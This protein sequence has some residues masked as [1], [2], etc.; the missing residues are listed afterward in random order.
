MGLSKIR[1]HFI[2]FN[3]FGVHFVTQTSLPFLNQHK[4]LD[5][6]ILYMTY[7]KKKNFHL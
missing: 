7:L 2:N 4:I 1:N 6:L 3:F 5:V